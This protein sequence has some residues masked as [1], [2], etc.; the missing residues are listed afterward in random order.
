MIIQTGFKGINTFQKGNERFA[1]QIRKGRV[2]K[3]K[4]IGDPVR[5][6][7]SNILTRYTNHNR[8][9]RH[10][11]DHH[12]I[13]ANTSIFAN[14]DGPQ[15]FRASTDHNPVTEWLGDVCPSQC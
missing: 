11:F 2:V 14:G 7:A 3:I 6:T 9:G 10:S 12:G 4:R 8:V 13:G 15:N 5:L 1:D